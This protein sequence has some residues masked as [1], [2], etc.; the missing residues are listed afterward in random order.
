MRGLSRNST[1]A[2]TPA[3]DAADGGTVAVGWREARHARC[4]AKDPHCGWKG[5]HSVP[6]SSSV[7]QAD[8]RGALLALKSADRLVRDLLHTFDARV[9]VRSMHAGACNPDHGNGDA[10]GDRPTA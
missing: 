5:H 8:N 2:K 9:E 10:V 3:G 7:G 4:H 1:S 6:A